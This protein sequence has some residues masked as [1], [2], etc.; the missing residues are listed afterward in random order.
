MKFFFVLGLLCF[1][2]IPTKAWPNVR[3]MLRKEIRKPIDEEG[4]PLFHEVN[5]KVADQILLFAK[6]VS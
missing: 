6:M 2:S 5:L 1:L 4:Q 3:E